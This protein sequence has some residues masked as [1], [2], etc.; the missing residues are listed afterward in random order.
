MA[1]DRTKQTL[2]VVEKATKKETTGTIGAKKA[3]INT[4]SEYN[5]KITTGDYQV[6]YKDADGN[7]SELVDVPGFTANP[8]TL[9]TGVTPSQT[10]MVLAVGANKKALTATISPEGATVKD[11]TY[12]SSAPE[13]AKVSATGEVTAVAEGQADI[14][15]TSKMVPTI[16][17]KCVVIVTPALN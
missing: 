10:T 2:V 16:T 15:V 12:M 14:T 6:Y 4:G 8:A 17:G 1:E 13:V 11:V 5:K 9:V 7:K 3:T